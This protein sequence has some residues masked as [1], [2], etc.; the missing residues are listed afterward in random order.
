MSHEIRAPMNAVI[1]LSQLL[2]QTSLDPDQNDYLYKAHN[3]SRILLG[4][5]ND[6]LDYSK[7]EAG[8]LELD[9]HVFVLMIFWSR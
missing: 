8:K 1:G 7:I 5:I 4:I 9:L 3:S 6:I 2:L